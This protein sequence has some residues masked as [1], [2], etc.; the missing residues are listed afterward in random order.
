[1]TALEDAHCREETDAGTE[2]GAADLE[3]TGKF[4]LGRK[5]VARMDLTAADEGAN[6]LDDLHGELTVA[7]HLVVKLFNLFFH[8]E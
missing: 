1:M 2:A 6:V 8:S 5:A 7:G 3:L 4:T